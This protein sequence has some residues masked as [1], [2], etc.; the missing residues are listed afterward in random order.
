MPMRPTGTGDCS[1]GCSYRCTSPAANGSAN[2]GARHRTSRGI[3]LRKGLGERDRCR[4]TKQEQQDQVSLHFA[5]ARP[6][7]CFAALFP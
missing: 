2:N 4:K 7:T 6:S 3:T 1:S 5:L